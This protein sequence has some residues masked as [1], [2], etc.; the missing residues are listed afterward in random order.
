MLVDKKLCLV[1]VR[2]CPRRDEAGHIF[3]NSLLDE[4]LTI[5]NA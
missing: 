3:V 2:K 5:L 4:T 1:K